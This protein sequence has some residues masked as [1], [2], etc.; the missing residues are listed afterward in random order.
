VSAAAF[1]LNVGDAVRVVTHPAQPLVVVAERWE[2]R[3]LDD[4]YGENIYAVSGFVTRQRE[5][6]LVPEGF[7]ALSLD[8]LEDW[9]MAGHGRFR[10]VG[11]GT[12]ESDGGPGVLWYPRQELEDFVLLID[13]RLTAPD[14][15]SGVFVRIPALGSTD[16]NRDWRPAAEQGYEIQIDDRGVDP[17]TG[18]PGDARRRTGAVYGLA[19]ARSGAARAVGAWNTFEIEARGPVLT[20][21]LN[22]QP[23]SRLD[24][25]PR[26]RRRGYVG[27][28][29][30]HPVARVQFRNPQVRRL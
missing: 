16:P 21:T 3:A 26:R 10:R 9:R 28:Q 25:D 17:A 4:P 2:G 14:D 18:I 7:A 19:P 11:P 30:H 29:A 8:R 6:S 1:R 27:L 24:G 15:N 12:A 5:T 20:V 22:G 23:V 13:W